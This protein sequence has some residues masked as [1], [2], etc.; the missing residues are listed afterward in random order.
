[1]TVIFL[2]SLLVLSPVVGEEEGV[3]HSGD[4][5]AVE[6]SGN[7][8]TDYLSSLDNDDAQGSGSSEME[9]IPSDSNDYE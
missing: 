8:N 7:D 5:V 9:I 4:G 3:E 2:V 6:G 1:M